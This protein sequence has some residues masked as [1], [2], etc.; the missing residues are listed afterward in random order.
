MKSY[1]D[2]GIQI[3][4]VVIG[5]LLLNLLDSFATKMEVETKITTSQSLVSKEVSD[6]KDEI[7][8]VKTEL[9]VL[10]SG[11]CIIDKRTCVLRD[12]EK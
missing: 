3:V 6:V 10:R 5:F 2:R 9:K 8:N 1:I 11:L 4:I 7:K 12:A